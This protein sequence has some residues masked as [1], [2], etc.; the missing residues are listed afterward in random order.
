MNDLSAASEIAFY[1]A[2]IAL[3]YLLSLMVLSLLSQRTQ[4]WPPPGRDSWQYKTLWVAIRL[5]VLC[6]GVVIHFDHS[7]LHIDTIFR[8]YVALPIF[9]V[10]FTLGSVAALQLGWKNTHGIADGFIEK[11]VYRYSRNP[12]YVFY[13]TSFL[14]LSIVVAS[15]K[16]AILLV[17][18]AV[19]YL[20]APFPEEKWLEK[21][22]G[23]RY[24]AYKSRVSRYIG[25]S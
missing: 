20:I 3:F 7:S 23:E 18:M 12:Q 10:S 5:L 21:E 19:W 13:A 4:F 17:T 25:W 9:I 1:L 16:V 6:I 8:F 22:Y 11:G 24:I 15:M 2:L 14:S